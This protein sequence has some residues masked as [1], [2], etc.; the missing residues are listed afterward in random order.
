MK[1][2]I[3]HQS[4]DEEISRKIA[5]RL[6]TLHNI[7]SYLDVI[8][9]F[10]DGPINALGDHIRNE[11]G[12]CT[13]LL[14][15][16]SPATQGSQWV[17]WEIG[18]ATEK[19]FP[20]ATYC[21]GQQPTLEFLRKWPYLSNEADLDSYAEIS[22]TVNAVRVQKLMSTSS[23]ALARNLTTPD[24]FRSLKAALRQT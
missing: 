9:R 10:I 4:K 3:S 15:V 8:D 14:A 18:V 7:E 21:S 19:N 1:V 16:V 5:N 17:P 13:Q 20:L 22:K 23:N 11:M 6:R 12:K 24:F 2:F